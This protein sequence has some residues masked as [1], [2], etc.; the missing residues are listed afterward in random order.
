M[1]MVE[2]RA[3]L[4]FVDRVAELFK[5]DKIIV[6]GSYAR[7]TPTP[8]SDVDLL[9]VKNHRGPGHYLASKIQLAVEAGFRMDLLV[10][11]AAEIR[12]EAAQKN[13]FFVEVLEQGITLYDGANQAVGAQG[14]R[15]L[16]RRLNSATVAQA[17]SV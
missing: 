15:R 9:V 5:P 13:W 14:R 3:I 6:F 11:S 7:G 12:R 8:D 17:Q 1:E 2:R 4:R 10:C 16:G